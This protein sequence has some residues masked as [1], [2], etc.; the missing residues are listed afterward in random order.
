[1]NFRQCGNC[2]FERIARA[3]EQRDVGAELRQFD[4]RRAADA[5]RAA[6]DERVF[7]GEIEIH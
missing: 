5:L 4:R 3:R 2:R 6:T 1:M 7:A